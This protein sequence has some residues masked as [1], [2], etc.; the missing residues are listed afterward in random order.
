MLSGHHIRFGATA[1]TLTRAKALTALAGP[2]AGR[3]PGIDCLFRIFQNIAIALTSA[4]A[5]FYGCFFELLPFPNAVSGMGDGL[6][7]STHLI[8]DGVSN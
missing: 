5:V 2:R 6:G 3:S 7:M 4:Q 8:S 1:A